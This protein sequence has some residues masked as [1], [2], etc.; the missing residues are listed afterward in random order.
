MFVATLTSQHIGRDEPLVDLEGFFVVIL[1]WL[2]GTEN[3]GHAKGGNDDHSEGKRLHD[4]LQSHN[5]HNN[6]FRHCSLTA[7]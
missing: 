4:V 1:C 5:N 6:L 2:I 7:V 3:V